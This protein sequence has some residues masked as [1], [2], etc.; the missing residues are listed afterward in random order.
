M[1]PHRSSR[2]CAD[3]ETTTTTT[4][5]TSLASLLLLPSLCCFADG[6]RAGKR[7]IGGVQGRVGA[8][9]AGEGEHRGRDGEYG[10]SVCC[11]VSSA[12]L[13]FPPQQAT[14]TYFF[15][16]SCSTLVVRLSSNRPRRHT[17]CFMHVGCRCHVCLPLKRLC[18]PR[19][20]FRLPECPSY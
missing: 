7:S 10:G 16:G 20:F 12:L 17:D 6:C 2:C 18:P 19:F 14:Y 5:T 3:D 13:S 4:T 9:P 8:T 1:K 11:C 15:I